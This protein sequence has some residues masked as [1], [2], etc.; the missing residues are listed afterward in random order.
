MQIFT[1]IRTN[2]IHLS[3]F[4]IS[5]I[6]IIHGTKALHAR[7]N[8]ITFFQLQRQ[9]LNQIKLNKLYSCVKIFLFLYINHV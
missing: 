7:K 2:K 4:P 1:R 9:Q 3:L 5:I 8:K 6:K